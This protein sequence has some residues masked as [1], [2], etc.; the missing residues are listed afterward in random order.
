MIISVAWRHSSRPAGF[1]PPLLFRP[2]WIMMTVLPAPRPLYFFSKMN[3]VK[4]HPLEIL[5]RSFFFFSKA[6][7][8]EIWHLKAGHCGWARGKR[9]SKRRVVLINKTGAEF[10]ISSL[11]QR[12]GA[13]NKELNMNGVKRCS[14][15]ASAVMTRPLS[16]SSGE[17]MLSHL[18]ILAICFSWIQLHFDGLL[19][20][21][22]L[23]Y[24][25]TMWCWQISAEPTQPHL[26]EAPDDLLKWLDGVCAAD[27]SCWAAELDALS[28]TQTL[29]QMI[30]FRL[31]QRAW[32][33]SSPFSYSDH[34]FIK[35]IYFP[36]IFMLSI[37]LYDFTD[38]ANLLYRL[39]LLQHKFWIFK[40]YNA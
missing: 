33:N 9:E 6:G 39:F 22:H 38:W 19:T 26:L 16:P 18:K 13:E 11:Y 32:K 35:L 29:I 3:K 17:E 36:W 24:I 7:R 37:I 23:F 2:T 1:S 28:R 27:A 34:S 30:V 31:L 10:I 20:S 5:H 14:G 12:N 4:S 25:W 40:I 8:G 21:C 15:G